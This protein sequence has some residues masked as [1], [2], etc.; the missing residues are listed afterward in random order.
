MYSNHSLNIPRLIFTAAGLLLCGVSITIAAHNGWQ[1]GATFTDQIVWAGAGTALALLSVSGMSMV[2]I[3]RG[4]TR[5]AL[6]GTVY[7]LGLGFTA[8]AAVGSQ[9]AGRDFNAA[10]AD[11]LQGQRAR[12]ESAYKRA[13]DSLSQLPAAR[14]AEIVQT[15]IERI[16][17][18]NGIHDCATTWDN[19]ILQQK[20]CASRIEPLKAEIAAGKESE[21]LKTEL[22]TL[23]QQLSS[24]GVAKTANA[25]AGALSNYLAVMGI[26]VTPGRIADILNLLTVAAIEVCGG[27][28]IALGSMQSH[29]PTVRLKPIVTVDKDMPD[30]SRL[31]LPSRLDEAK[32]ALLS[33]LERNGCTSTLGPSNA[34]IA[35]ALNCDRTT[36]RNAAKELADSNQIKIESSHRIGTRYVLATGNV[37]P[38]KRTA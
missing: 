3:S 6:A 32:R 34:D 35:K 10:T 27:I 37:I 2:L 38:L 16:M 36:L 26:T 15:D 4:A 9:H 5:K 1:R 13:S 12:L 30:N 17:L 18:A 33:Y 31:L 7:L 29:I 21:R 24:L 23:T 14:P 20:T 28:A 22:A 11:S 19:T 25:D 8:I